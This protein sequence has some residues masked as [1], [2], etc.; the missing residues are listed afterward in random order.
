M[1]GQGGADPTRGHL[2]L[3]EGTQ[4]LGDDQTAG[5]PRFLVP[6]VLGHGS[7]A[8]TVPP[9]QGS[10]DPAFVQGGQGSARS[11][12]QQQPFLV[13]QDRALG[14]NDDRNLSAPG[15]LPSFQTLEAIDDLEGAI[16]PQGHA[17]RQICQ[18]LEPAPS[19]TRSERSI[20]RSQALGIQQQGTTR[21]RFGRGCRSRSVG[22]GG[23]PEP[24]RY[25]GRDGSGG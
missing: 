9:D 1:L 16:L 8:Q 14:F 18:I 12:G 4:A 7:D 21:L 20:G 22:H 19:P 13:I 23:T 25:G 10:H 5:D 3:G 11:I 15:C 17:K 2:L 24:C 6:Q